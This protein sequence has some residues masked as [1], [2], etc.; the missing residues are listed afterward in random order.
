M[1]GR[2]AADPPLLRAATRGSALARWQTDHVGELLAAATNRGVSPVVLSTAGDRDTSTPLHVIGGKGVFVKEIQAAVLDG[3][4]DIAVHSAKDLPAETP[5]GLTL[6][7]VPTRA[8]ARDVLVGCSLG[9]LVPGAV[10]GTGSV[11]RRAQLDALRPDLRFAELR[12]NIDTRLGKIGEFDAIVMAAA[13]L[14]RLGRTPEVVDRL[15]VDVMI[16]QVGQGALAVECRVDDTATI[17]LLASI[18]DPVARVEFDAE[19]AFLSELGG[20]CDLPAGA[21][22]RVVDDGV[23][24]RAFLSNGAGVHAREEGAGSDGQELGRGLAR[25]LRGRVG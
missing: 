19:R 21:H 22:A 16:P 12:G 5:L 8:D 9:E 6:A 17:A 3:R 20:D 24:M 14:D 25:A 10:I 13:A 18:E 11:R 1:T 15:D 7:C 4:A 2:A 23:E